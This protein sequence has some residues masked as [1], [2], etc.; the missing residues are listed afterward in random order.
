M[1]VKFTNNASTTVGTGINASAN[2]LTVASAS[3]FPSLSGTDDYCYLTLQGA[4]NTTREVVKA[5]ALSG[6][7]FTIVRAQDNTSAASWVAGDVVELRMTAALLTDV[8]DAATVEGVKTNYQYTPTAGQTVFSGAD[9]AS[10]TMI[11]NQAALVS[12]YMNGVRLV[13]G[14]DYTVS[15]ANNTV[16]LGIGATTADIIDIEVY[17]NFV[18]QSGAAVGITGG[19]ITGT[20]ITATSLSATGTATLNTLV[21][22]NATISGGSLDGVTI[23][24]TTRGA[25]SGNAISGTSFAST[26]NMTFGDNDKAIFGAGGDLQIYS[27]GTTGQVTGNVN[28]TG[29]VTA[30]GLTVTGT[31]G[32]WSIDS[33]GVIQTFTRNS[34][35]YI[36]AS[37][38]S[39]ALRFDTG[40]SIGR[41]NIASNGDVSL[42]EDTGT[43]PKLAWSA[44]NERLT[45][46]GSDYQF[47]IQQGANQPWYTRAVSDGTF[48]LHLNGT[49]DV[50]TA[51][52]SGNVGIG[53]SSPRTLL[54]VTGLTGDD[55]PALGSSAAP[56]FISNTANSYGLN[57]GVN[58]AGAGWLQAQS[59]TASTAYNLLLNP[60]GGN[61]GIGT[62]SPANK[63]HVAGGKLQITGATGGGAGGGYLSGETATEFHI[64]SEDYTGAGYADIV[65][66]SGNGS[67]SS[68]LERMRID[69][70]GN[71]GIGTSSPDYRLE[72]EEAGTGSGLGGIAA[73]T[74]TAGGNAGY[75]W[76]TGGT[77]RF[78]MA[79]IGSAGL[80]GLRIYDNNNASERMR[81]DASGN[82]GIGQS[83]PYNSSKLD[84]V[85]SIISTSQTIGTYA[86][87][88]AG[89]DFAAGTKVGRFFSTSSDATGGHMTF[90]TGAGGGSERMRIDASGNVGIGTSSPTSGGGLTLSSSTTAQGFIDFKN[91]VDGDSGFIGNAKALVTGGATNQ[92]GVRGG[93][94][95]IAFSVA[96]AE[97]MRIDTSGNLLVGKIT[98]ALA[99][100]GLTLGG[101]GFASLTRSGAEA[102]NVNRLSSDG[103]LAVFYKDSAVVG[104]IG[105]D[106]SRFK[107]K[108]NSLALYLENEGNKQLVWGNVSGV[109][110]FYPQ[111]DND[112]NIGFPTQRFKDLTLSGTSNVGVGRF[113]AQSLVHSAATLVLGHE[114]SSKSQI[115]AYGINAGT[116]GSLEFMVSASDG[117]GSNSMTLDASGNL[118]VGTTSATGSGA[119]SGKQVNQ[120]NGAVANGLYVDDTR[121][122]AGTDVA[123]IFGRGATITGSITTTLTTTAYV[124]SS[125][126]RLKENIAD[127]DDA[128]S[129][130]DAIQ[131][132]KFDW[133]ADGSHQDYGMV[134]QELLEVAPEAVSAPEDPEEMMGVDYSKL[135]PMMLKEIQ[136]LRARIA[137][138]ES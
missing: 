15:S 104:S 103:D 114:G 77:A 97:A 1:T 57:I 2:S 122:A 7:T 6:N 109:P 138:L 86:A 99:T 106:T 31:L 19:S 88:N 87:N 16:T 21:S 44:T 28:V 30:D 68:Y 98:T 17:G 131:V 25:I 125:D 48:R 8:I 120:F 27:D 22:N 46:T 35:N 32:N 137:A 107:V 47:N 79:T 58:N 52:T 136:S 126:Q 75:R 80:E 90:V 20:A 54:H 3:S 66:D 101:A 89:F 14:T 78:A 135:V 95:G 56:V 116:I 123:I 18:G 108:S 65:F 40:G 29:T 59:N 115:R 85:G 42:Y 5:T 110:Y 62:S 82:V 36:R 124:T 33:Q 45:L 76:V 61:V 71:V 55:D 53:T 74:A 13:Q 132:R 111:S 38:A 96:S 39:G 34:T 119:S 112:T 113:T 73:A 50:L 64:V 51:D 127:A 10:A 9:N 133:K 70:S 117:T 60:L 37:D 92:L 105:T 128:G 26:G 41:L 23:G 81:I 11:I 121:T 93:T 102:L 49:G 83:A 72:V 118:L 134:A 24:G 129:K 67:G 130:I 12:V 84:V 100:A 43:T 4:T 69:S 63:L 94:S 91:T